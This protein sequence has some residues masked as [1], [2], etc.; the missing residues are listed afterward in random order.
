MTGNR[1]HSP[2]SEKW[3]GRTAETSAIRRVT[4][5]AV[6]F[7]LVPRQNLWVRSKT[8]A[9]ARQRGRPLRLHPRIDPKRG[10][11]PMPTNTSCVGAR[12]SEGA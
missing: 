8:S 9:Q 5:I 11:G 1:G 4:S 2:F 6:L 10:E 3:N 7:F 12:E